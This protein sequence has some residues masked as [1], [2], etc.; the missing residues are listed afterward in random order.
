MTGQF[1]IEPP[2]WCRALRCRSR[3]RQFGKEF[4]GLLCTPWGIG[5]GEAIIDWTSALAVPARV[6]ATIVID[7]GVL[8]R[9]SMVKGPCGRSAA[10]CDADAAAVHPSLSMHYP[11]LR[12][13]GTR[14]QSRGD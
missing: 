7:F 8:W 3:L 10:R 4:V 5:D 6:S 2:S 11:A 12:S 13:D 1:G 9:S 14:A